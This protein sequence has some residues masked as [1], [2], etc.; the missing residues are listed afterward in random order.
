M[1]VYIRGGRLEFIE[2]KRTGGKTSEA[3]DAWHDVLV[4][5]D[6]DVYIVNAGTPDDAVGAMNKLMDELLY[7]EGE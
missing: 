5:L 6:F 1:R 2:L 3:Q 7:G 4:D